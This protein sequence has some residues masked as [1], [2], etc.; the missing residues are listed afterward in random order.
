MSAYSDLILSLSPVAYWR[1]GESSGSSAADASGNSRAGTYSGSYTLGASSLIPS[2]TG[3]TSLGVAG[4]G[5]VSVAHDSAFV[6]SSAFTL[7]GRYKRTS[8]TGDHCF[9]HKGDTS[10]G[11]Q[12]GVMVSALSGTNDVFVSFFNGSWSNATASGVIPGTDAFSFA[13]VYLG[14]TSAKVVIDGVATSITLPAALPNSTQSLNLFSLK[15]TSYGTYFVGGGDDVAW[16]GSALSDATLLSIHQAAIA[17]DTGNFSISSGSSPSFRAGSMVSLSSGSSFTP[18]TSYRAFAIQG[19]SIVAPVTN[20]RNFAIAGSS[21]PSIRAGTMFSLSG[22]STL[23][24]DAMALVRSKATID[25]GTSMNVPGGAI[26]TSA[27]VVATR[28]ATAFKGSYNARAK[29]VVSGKTTLAVRSGTLSRVVASVFSGSSLSFKHV[30]VKPAA[31]A[32][33]CGSAFS[34]SGRAVFPAPF[35]I[36]SNTG[37]SPVAMSTKPSVFS[38]ASSATCAFVSAYSLVNVPGEPD[39]TAHVFTKQDSVSVVSA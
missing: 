8:T 35:S 5:Y 20:Q 7:I 2:D 15:Q 12:Q 38:G 19:S 22:S 34:F 1:L 28:S 13:F 30:S 11:G 39:F 9:F 36:G 18:Q 33:G 17:S 27:V 26:F 31:A 6:T 32:I 16:F 24:T 4:A 3:D 25:S 23:T 21:S 37:F 29:M 14:G 10:V